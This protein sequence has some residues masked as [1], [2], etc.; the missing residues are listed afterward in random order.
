VEEEMKTILLVDSDVESLESIAG[1]LTRLGYGI[2]AMQSGP[3][4]LRVIKEGM[5]IDLV[6]TASRIEGMD[7]LEMLSVLKK[8]VPQVPLIMIT[9]DT[10]I[11]IY[12]K[13]LSLGVFE[14]L[15]KPVKLREI[16]RIVKGAFERSH[17]PDH[18]HA[19]RA[20]REMLL[21]HTA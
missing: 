7:G 17:I 14:Y 15:N 21:K 2:I 19:A 1:I 12:L 9:A 13:A 10:S 20:P 3:S 4:A 11:E 5:Q 16:G 18:V 6:I 8:T